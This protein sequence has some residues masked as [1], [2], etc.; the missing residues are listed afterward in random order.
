MPVTCQLCHEHASTVHLTELDPTGTLQELHLCTQC[1][2]ARGVDLVSPPPLSAL[3]DQGTEAPPEP[4]THRACPVCG[5]SMVDYRQSNLLGCSACIAAFGQPF[6]DLVAKYHGADRHAG[7][8]PVAVEGARPTGRST[9]RSGVLRQLQEAV[10]V[11][12]YDA[13]ARLRDQLKS[14]DEGGEA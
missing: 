10:Q 6:L 14:L 13:A 5:L 8:L 11:E 12:D 4:S 2:Q 9:R 3:T 7:R 1:V